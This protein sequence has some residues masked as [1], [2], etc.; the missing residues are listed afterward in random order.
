MANSVASAAPRGSRFPS[1]LPTLGV[2]ALFWV[3]AVL[4]QEFNRKGFAEVAVLLA[5]LA[6]AGAMIARAGGPPREESAGMR[7]ALGALI[8]LLL[9]VQLGYAGARLWHPHVADIAH[10]AFAGGEAMA[11]GEN[12]YLLPLDPSGLQALGPRFQGYKYLPLMGWAY[13]P[14]GLPFGDRGL[15]ATNLLL[16]LA[17]AGLVWRLARDLATGTAGRIAV[18]LYL[19]VPLVLM[20]AISKVSTDPVAVVPLLLALL[21]WE[22]RPGISGLLVG[23]SIAAKL[24]PGALFVPCLLPPTASARWRY[25]LGLACGLLP[26]V[27]YAAGAPQAFFDNIVIFNALRPSDESSWLMS[28]PAPVSWLAHGTLVLLLLAAVVGVWRRAPPLFVRCG[29]CAILMLAALVLGPSPH[30]NYHLW[31]L[32]LYSVLL[33]ATL[34]SGGRAE[35]SPESGRSR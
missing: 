19:A 8:G 31:W 18:C 17:T 21:C 29:L 35:T 33:A 32:P 25:A 26:I 30:Q 20:Q 34:T 28:M 2:A 11:R 6:G 22:R 14:L 27:P 5:F 15:V 24:T 10:W 4:L 23:L 9:I 1:A 12:P 7:R 3:G 16:Q 13:L